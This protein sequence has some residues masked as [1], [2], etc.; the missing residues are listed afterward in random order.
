MTTFTADFFFTSSFSGEVRDSGILTATLFDEDLIRG[1]DEGERIEDS[2][3][4]AIFNGYTR[5]VQ[6]G[7]GLDDIVREFE[8]GEATTTVTFS[9]GSSLSGVLG[10][11]DQLVFNFG[12]TSSLF[13][14]DVEALAAVGKTIADVSGV[15]IDGFVD[16]DLS[17]AD[18]GFSEA[19]EPDPEPTPE[20]GNAAPIAV[21]DFYQDV[22]GGAPFE[23]SAE[24]GVLSNDG[25]PDGDDITAAL[26]SGPS[27]GTLEFAADGSFTYTADAGFSGVDFFTYEIT[28]GTDTATANVRLE[29]TASADPA[30]ILGTDGNDRLR[31][32]AADETIIGGAGSDRLRGGA[33]ADTFVF[34]ADAADGDRDRDVIR[35]FDAAEDVIVIEDGAAIRQVTE[36]RGDVFVQLEGDRDVIVIRD[37]DASVVD[38]FVFL[39]ELFLG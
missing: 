21:F 12:A 22:D 36:R 26:V 14:L 34:G 20:P 16:H 7:T 19:P 11:T 31:G 33:G 39:D 5:F 17:Y 37:A 6:T 10:L 38:G 18:L 30:L 1:D 23:V 3:G 4:L 27:G 9:D 32:T 29:V 28:D 25:D 13:L 24:D 2:S 8:L 15:D 35:D